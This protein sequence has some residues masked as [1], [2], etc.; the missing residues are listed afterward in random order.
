MVDGAT[1]INYDGT[2]E[3]GF[4]AL[5]V[6]VPDSAGCWNEV[7]TRNFAEQTPVFNEAAGEKMLDNPVMIVN[8]FREIEGRRQSILVLGDADCI[9]NGQFSRNYKGIRLV[10]NFNVVLESFSWFTNGEFPIN[11]SRPNKPDNDISLSMTGLKISK[12][13]F[14]G[15]I[16]VLL[17]LMGGVKLIRRARK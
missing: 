10:A 7:E 11:T 5:P 16:P 1:W 15:L 6:I 14:L 4:N 3:K 9:G 8:L 2:V 17:V 13:T 12:V